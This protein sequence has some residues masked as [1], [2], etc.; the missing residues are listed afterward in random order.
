MTPMEKVWGTILGVL[1]GA[2]VLFVGT[3]IV[4]ALMAIFGVSPPFGVLCVI[5]MGMGGYFGGKYMFA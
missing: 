4:M 3:L 5:V 2:V 1:I